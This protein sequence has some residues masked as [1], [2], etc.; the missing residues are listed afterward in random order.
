M[1]DAG[2]VNGKIGKR[3]VGWRD[4]CNDFLA[5]K[6]YD[7]MGCEVAHAGNDGWYE[8]TADVDA[9]NFS[10]SSNVRTVQFD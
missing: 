7:S 6:K 5:A 4:F 8:G 9:L 1:W 2:N 10:R 3:Q